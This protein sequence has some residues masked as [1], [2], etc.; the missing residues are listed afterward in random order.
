MKV[1]ELGAQI[2]FQKCINF[3]AL[4]SSHQNFKV[5]EKLILNQWHTPIY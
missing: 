5:N 4:T 1:G 2:G 3:K